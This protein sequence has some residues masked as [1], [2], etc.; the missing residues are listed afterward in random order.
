MHEEVQPSASPVTAMGHTADLLLGRQE[1]TVKLA[2]QGR[3]DVSNVAG[4]CYHATSW[5]ERML[6]PREVK[7]A[8]SCCAK[9]VED[10]LLHVVKQSFYCC[11]STYFNS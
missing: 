5:A 4:H 10:L 6:A 11:K 7:P 2:I 8:G 9:E 1:K 3:L